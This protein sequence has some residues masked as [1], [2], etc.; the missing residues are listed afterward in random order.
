MAE[1]AC[2]KFNK[3]KQEGKPVGIARGI[4]AGENKALKTRSESAD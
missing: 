2:V 3:W 1:P 4:S